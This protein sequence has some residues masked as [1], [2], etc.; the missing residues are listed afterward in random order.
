MS[1]QTEDVNRLQDELQAA[2]KFADQTKIESAD[3]INQLSRSLE[4]TQRHLRDI[5]DEGRC[6][7]CMKI[8]VH[9]WV[10]M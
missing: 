9:M 8:C 3:T 4:A 2:R 5:L 7:A 10:Y 6:H 1:L